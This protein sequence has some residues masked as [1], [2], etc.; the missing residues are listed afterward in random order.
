M[1]ENQI[2]LNIVAATEAMQNLVKRVDVLEK[3]LLNTK[4]LLISEIFSHI[5]GYAIHIGSIQEVGEVNNIEELKRIC[6]TAIPT[7]FTLFHVHY[8]DSEFDQ[9]ENNDI[10]NAFLRFFGVLQLK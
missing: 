1:N 6:S 9:Y 4:Q 8:T 7:E 10:L 3:E 5:G 2:A